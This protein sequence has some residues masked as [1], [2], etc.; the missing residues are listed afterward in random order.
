MVW[1]LDYVHSTLKEIYHKSDETIT[2][3]GGNDSFNICEKAREYFELKVLSGW[4]VTI[5]KKLDHSLGYLNCN[6]TLSA[7]YQIKTSP[8]II[9]ELNADHSMTLLATITISSREDDLAWGVLSPYTFPAMCVY[10]DLVESQ[11]V[12][13]AQTNVFRILVSHG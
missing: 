2:S 11:A 10:L 13:D 6:N 12:C 5:A 4:Y 3:L 8:L 9:I 7:L 1:L